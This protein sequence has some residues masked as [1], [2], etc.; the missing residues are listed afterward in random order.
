MSA[1]TLDQ[2]VDFCQT[3]FRQLFSQPFQGQI[4]DRLRRNQVV[5]QVEGAADA[6]SQSLARLLSHQRLGEEEVAAVLGGM[7]PLGEILKLEDLANPNMTPE[8]MVPSLLER[9]PVPET[10]R[11]SEREALYRVALHSLLQALTYI[12]PV[13]AEWQKLNFSSAFELP[14]RVIDRLNQI[15][16]QLDSF[17][18]PG[19]AAA[20]ERYELLYRD[21]LL[22]RFHRVEAGTVRM[23]TNMDVDLRELFVMPRVKLRRLGK[24]SLSDGHDAVGL[25]D[26]AAARQLFGGS[27]G[28]GPKAGV[29]EENDEGTPA[30]ERLKVSNRLV[31]VGVP[32]SGK[33]TFLEWL[34]LQLAAVE[35]EMVMA[36][37][38]AIP[39][40]LRV[41]QL[42]PLDLPQ[43][44][45][46][47]EK[48]T[49]SRDRADLMPYEWLERQL[50]QGRVIL[51]LDGLDELDPGLRDDHILPWLAGLCQRYPRCRYVVSSRPVGYPPGTLRALEF[52]ECDLLDFGSAEIEE[53]TRHW[54][55]AVRL[56]RNEPGEE[57]RREGAVDGAAIV[58]GFK[59]HPYISNLARN[60]LMLSAVCLVN[61]FEQGKLPKDRALLYK[62]CVEGLVHV[63]DQR[64]GIH[65][66]FGLEEKMSACRDL[67][68]R[69]QDLSRLRAVP[70]Q[71]RP[72]RQ[73]RRNRH[74]PQPRS[75]GETHA[76]TLAYAATAASARGGAGRRSEAGRAEGLQS[77]PEGSRRQG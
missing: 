28:F 11:K 64:R 14:R 62:L 36:G 72:Q 26:L 17:G 22:Q 69:G 5:R 53:Y 46:L 4:A 15:S 47:I 54:C 71:E 50:E 56:A 31:I 24:E 57:A 44:A 38:Q 37:A 27:G 7:A 25:M 1:S 30:L 73:A 13:L 61:Y 67:A 39:L 45:A 6:A 59:D 33:S 65:S 55:T 60:P 58:Q 23:T 10:L 43:G 49:A 32:G 66:E 52:A 68:S 40:L 74:L 18:Q 76:G 3:L 12:G 9:L 34:Q 48:A 35:E 63:W 75:S 51:M 42:D 2:V 77:L 16:A 29:R 70:G 21:Y 8:A 19:G 41:R 20:D